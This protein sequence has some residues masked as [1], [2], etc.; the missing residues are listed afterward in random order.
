MIKIIFMGIL[1]FLIIVLEMFIVEYDV[2]VV[3]M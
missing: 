1:D 3:V 2:I